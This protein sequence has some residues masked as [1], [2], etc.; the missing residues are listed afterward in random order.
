MICKY[1]DDVRKMADEALHPIEDLH[2]LAGIEKLTDDAIKKGN[3]EKT[4]TEI[5]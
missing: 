3:I 4:K 2:E 5:K 1:C